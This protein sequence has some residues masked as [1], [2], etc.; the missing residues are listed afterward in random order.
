MYDSLGHLVSRLPLLSSTLFGMGVLEGTHTVRADA[1]ASLLLLDR[2]LP[3]AHL[4]CGITHA[5][6]PEAV[7]SVPLYTRDASGAVRTQLWDWQQTE[8]MTGCHEL[9]V[10]VSA[11]SSVDQTALQTLFSKP[12]EVTAWGDMGLQPVPGASGTAL[13]RATAY[14]RRTPR[15]LPT[16]DALTEVQG[17]YELLR[18]SV[19]RVNQ[20]P[21]MRVSN[22]SVTVTFQTSL[23]S[24]AQSGSD[25]D[26]V[27]TFG[28]EA[29]AGSE[30]EQ[31]RQS[32][33]LTLVRMSNARLLE[34]LPELSIVEA[35][36]G[37]K[38]A[39]ISF[40][41]AAGRIGSCA[42][43]VVLHDSG[44]RMRSNAGTPVGHDTSVEYAFT[45]TL[46][47]GYMPTVFRFRPLPPIVISEG[48]GSFSMGDLVAEEDIK[49]YRDGE[50]VKSDRAFVLTH[51]Y[52]VPVTGQ[53]VDDTFDTPP[54][55]SLPTSFNST[56]S[57]TLTFAAKPTIHGSL[58]MGFTL[59]DLLAAADSGSDQALAGPNT[60]Q[61]IFVRIVPVNSEPI[62]E[63][64]APN[65]TLPSPTSA[66]PT[67]V[68][69]RLSDVISHLS[70]GA[71]DE[72]ETQTLALRITTMGGGCSKVFDEAVRPPEVSFQG[73]PATTASLIMHLVPFGVGTCEMEVTAVDSASPPLSVTRSV[74]IHVRA[75][76]Q[77]PSFRLL[78]PH[79]LV[80]E[81]SGSHHV[82]G[83]LGNISSGEASWSEE[84]QKISFIVSTAS[85][86]PGLFE[87][88]PSISAAGLLEFR[89]ARAQAGRATVM[90]RARDDG[91]TDF[92]GSDTSTQHVMTLQVLPLPSL[93][94]V[95]PMW[96][97][98]NQV[99]AGNLTLTVRGAFLSPSARAQ[100]RGQTWAARQDMLASSPLPGTYVLVNGHA[101][102]QSELISDSE[103]R[104]H[105][106]QAF[107]RSAEVRVRVLEAPSD[108]Q[109][110]G[111]VREATL[112]SWHHVQ[113][114][115]LAVAGSTSDGRGFVATAALSSAI[116]MQPL[117]LATD[118]PVRSL[119]S[120]G[121]SGFLLAAGTFQTATS[122]SPEVTEG[123]SST[124]V[125]REG[126]AVPTKYV[127][128]TKRSAL[129]ETGGALSYPST[130]P[131]PLAH[132]LDGA[133]TA[134]VKIVQKNGTSEFRRGGEWLLLAG[135]FTS[136]YLKSS[137]GRR[138]AAPTV[139]RA[140]GLVLWG[141]P[142][143]HV[144]GHDQLASPSETTCGCEDAEEKNIFSPLPAEGMI[145]GAMTA[146]EVFV[147]TLS[148]P[149]APGNSPA[150]E[151]TL[152]FVAGRFTSV[153]APTDGSG[154]GADV[155]GPTREAGGLMVLDWSSG[156]WQALCG[157]VNTSSPAAS[158]TLSGSSATCRAQV[159]Q[160]LQGC[161]VRGGDIVAMSASQASCVD[162]GY[163]LV[164]AGTFAH[165]G[166]GSKGGVK[167]TRGLAVWDGLSWHSLGSVDGKG[168]V[169]AL[170][171]HG[172]VLF[173]AGAFSGVN[174]KP[175]SNLASFVSGVW[176]E[177]G[178]GVSGSVYTL[179]V[180]A[181][182]LLVGGE[183]RAVGQRVAMAP[184]AAGA[185]S[186][187]GS[188]DTALTWQATR[189]TDR[190]G[191]PIG[192]LCR[193]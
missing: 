25:Q 168:W 121:V 39:N 82:Q 79:L 136:A 117:P 175:M 141:P 35:A 41:P 1:T 126:K 5:S 173:V 51:F 104:C 65:I 110:E 140:R 177:V 60:T 50:Q 37:E 88:E 91:G 40:L 125:A 165:A 119:L 63:L 75:V 90:M 52:Q 97:M 27:A 171:R 148:G 74:L 159:T 143:D 133:V 170:A 145:E 178:G 129:P 67:P 149:T 153:P 7:R 157:V 107:S 48:S 69:V 108:N 164:V 57:V 166:G 105:G 137:P 20:R 98:A 123:G 36:G 13:L 152:V 22:V 176:R 191:N 172:R 181:S 154:A 184:D 78:T 31:Q 169:M 139:V 93:T 95:A 180:T 132:G 17:T 12:P 10:N 83:V 71:A 189:T 26:Y 64:A 101:C 15:R 84:T 92:N 46:L 62:M 9:S 174:G 4:A 89:L 85:S 28:F 190:F 103:V 21:T 124:E 8:Y 161:G 80:V 116:L 163:E 18:A 193:S 111:V 87:I 6:S 14:A 100:G 167:S 58:Y 49:V 70:T 77:A 2:S 3:T 47:G 59:V 42:L 32:L 109:D 130:R 188:S 56:A 112:G 29:S 81:G 19:A 131:V 134:M 144:P 11:D 38:R 156:K 44:G 192:N 113:R 155:L 160:E 16:D 122:S 127:L 61:Y 186:A 147:Q 68:Q 54:R 182:S 118:R 33:S 120:S 102:E 30:E 146:V 96:W 138:G 114:I 158:H 86:P 24:A 94:S 179:A 128:S 135:S 187:S 34:R 106:I 55:L 66:D 183:I 115:G 150:R 73:F 53:T 23:A 99:D 151:R 185:A 72:D 76:N 43:V 142:L 45:L 162:C